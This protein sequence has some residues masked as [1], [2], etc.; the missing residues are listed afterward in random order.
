M[1]GLGE[2]FAAVRPRPEVAARYRAQG[3]WRDRTPLDDLR[4]AA[5]TVPGRVALINWRHAERRVCRLTFAELAGH[6]ERHAAGLSRLGIARGDVVA[7]QLPS[8]WELAVLA[9]ACAHRGAVFMPM[10][11]DTGAREAE[12]MLAA[13]AAGVL[14]TVDRWGNSEPARELADRAGRLPALRH[15]VVIG[16]DLP[17]GALGYGACLRDAPGTCEPTPLGPDDVALLHASSGTTGHPT[18]ALHS[19]NTTHAALARGQRAGEAHTARAPAARAV[20]AS[21]AYARGYRQVVAATVLSRGP[22]VF[23]DCHDPRA[24]LDLIATYEVARLP[25]T[26]IGLERLAQAQIAEPRPLTG[27]RLAISFGSSLYAHQAR[28]IRQAFGVPLLNAWGS[29]EASA[30][31]STTQG[32]PPDWA[33]HSI[34]R[35]RPGVEL[36]LE[37][38]DQGWMGEDGGRE[39]GG[40]DD[41]GG[42]DSGGDDSGGEDGAGED[43]VGEIAVRSASVCLGTV[44]RDGSGLTWRPDDTGG[45]YHSGDLARD[46]GRGGLRYVGRAAERISCQN[47]LVPVF[48][49]E[50]A[51]HAHPGIREVAVVGYHDPRAGQRAAAVIV[52]A[53]GAG[54]P[55]VAELRR[56][57]TDCGMTSWYHPT[58]VRAVPALPRTA[59]GKVRKDLLRRQ[60]EDA[61]DMGTETT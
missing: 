7:V 40:G 22:A 13:T 26:P 42:D 3:W 18:W 61:G 19:F 34:G 35:A 47:R 31:T 8:W 41:S 32:D 56:F 49:V 20:L 14:V 57:L 2:V 39:D 9:L 53:P 36:R 37:P 4:D 1:N 15:L 48:S 25:S 52:P 46:D 27:L 21:P 16:D 23:A 33:E 45:W 5:A 51:L 44:D 12:R 54:P 58:R 60:L 29:T 28:L 6:V 17:A 10:H 38:P 59:M 50:E 30:C 55:E 43:G 11:V 24:V